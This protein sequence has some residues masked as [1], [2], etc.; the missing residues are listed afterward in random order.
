[1]NA[2]LRPVRRPAGPLWVNDTHSALN[3]T[4]VAR[5]LEPRRATD[6]AEAVR[7]AASRSA[8]VAIAGGRRLLRGRLTQR[9][10]QRSA[11]RFNHR[12]IR[13]L[14]GRVPLADVAEHPPQLADAGAN[15]LVTRC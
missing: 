7:Q 13:S 2:R 14:L 3:R 9:R 8:P 10:A 11:E 5:L 4:P 1:M 15:E 6:V 12:T